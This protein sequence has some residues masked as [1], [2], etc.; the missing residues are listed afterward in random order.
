MKELNDEINELKDHLHFILYIIKSTDERMFT[1]LEYKM[2]NEISKQ[3][4]TKILYIL[5]HSSQSVDKD[6]KLDMI[7]IGIKEN[8]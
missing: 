8:L 4:D 5:T 7:N 3:K 6:E 1:D 2:L